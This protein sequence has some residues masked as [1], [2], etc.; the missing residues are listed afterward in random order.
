MK[1][2]AHTIKKRV[3]HHLG[4]G[5]KIMLGFF[6][7]SIVAITI[8]AFIPSVKSNVVKVENRLIDDRNAKT[9]KTYEKSGRERN[10]DAHSREYRPEPNKTDWK[11]SVNWIIGALNGFVLILYNIKN[12]FHKQNPK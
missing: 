4:L 6:A 5:S 2:V 11:S 8:V 10:T 7:L 1:Q 9:L 3:V 12:I